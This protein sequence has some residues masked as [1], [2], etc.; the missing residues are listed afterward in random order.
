MAINTAV[1]PLRVAV[2]GASTNPNR[3]AHI[4]VNRLKDKGHLPIP[5][6][7]ESGKI[8]DTNIHVGQP[9]LSEI[10]T[11]TLYLR[12]SKQK[13]IYDYILGL[14]P[15]RIIF[16]PGAENTELEKLARAHGILPVRACTMVMLATGAF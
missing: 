9:K 8:G 5:I 3:Y 1:K 13:A 12:A 15:E 7:L 2:I 16:N 6:G 4:A 11:I 14:K 10:H